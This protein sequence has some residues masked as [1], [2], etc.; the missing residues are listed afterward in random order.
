MSRSWDCNP[1][2]LAQVCPQP[3]LCISSFRWT[4]LICGS[5]IHKCYNI[6]YNPRNIY[7]SLNEDY[8]QKSKR[9]NDKLRQRAKIINTLFI[10]RNHCCKIPFT[11]S[12]L[13]MKSFSEPVSMGK[14]LHTQCWVRH[15]QYNGDEKWYHP[16]F[17][18]L[19]V[20]KQTENKCSHK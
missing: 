18:G 6:P 5:V 7:S 20:M 11:E 10:I 19:A 13:L 15:K 9:K 12:L 1:G 4:D 2:H 14:L 16:A 8:I 17:T 3:S